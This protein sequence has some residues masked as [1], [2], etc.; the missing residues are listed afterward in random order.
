MK[1]NK[2][3]WKTKGNRIDQSLRDNNNNINKKQIISEI[4][5]AGLIPISLKI[6]DNISNEKSYDFEREVIQKIGRLNENSILTNV[7]KGSTSHKRNSTTINRN[8]YLKCDKAKNVFAVNFTQQKYELDDGSLI[9]EKLFLDL[10]EPNYN[11]L[12]Y[13][14]SNENYV[15]SIEDKD[16]TYFK[17][18]DGSTIPQILFYQTF[19]QVEKVNPEKFF[20]VNKSPVEKM[21]ELGKEPLKT[22]NDKWDGTVKKIKIE[23]VHPEPQVTKGPN[24]DK[25]K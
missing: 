7:T 3:K 8:F 15:V 6:Y 2:E 11:N 17:L 18:S 10:F 21:Q 4:F 20:G 9:N 23:E 25:N 19:V 13:L 12:Y 24:I 14:R 1:N 5:E 16:D 22:H